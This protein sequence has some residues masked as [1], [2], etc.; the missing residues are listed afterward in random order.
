MTWQQQFFDGAPHKVEVSPQKIATQR[1]L[2]LRV[3][4]EI[5]AERVAPPLTVRLTALTYFTGIVVIGLLSGLALYR[6][7]SLRSSN[8]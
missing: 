5:E 8:G 6:R 1:F 4:R 7:F 2:P 3:K